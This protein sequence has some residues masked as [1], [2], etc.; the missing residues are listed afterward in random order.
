MSPFFTVVIPTYNCADYL[1]RAL[2]SVFSQTYQNF[3][4]IVVDN[5]STDHTKDVLRSFNDGRLMVIKVN[6]N[7]IIAYSRNKGIENAKG[8]WIA[9]LD[10]DDIWKP[11][12]L[13]KVKKS[14]NQNTEVVLICHDEHYVEN[15]K[16]KKRLRYGPAVKNLYQKLL[17]KGNCVSTSATCI[18]KNIA[19]ET[20]GFS[21][22]KE[23]KTAED[24]EYW[25]RLA[26]V[27]QFYFIKE[28]LGEFHI[29]DKNSSSDIH[30]HTSAGIAVKEYHFSLWLSKF[31]NM[32]KKVNYGR[33]KMYADTGAT[34][35]RSNQFTY[36]REYAIKAI[37]F[38]PWYWKVWI[39]LL[40]GF[41]RIK[42]NQ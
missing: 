23:F 8:D 19:I 11:K 12:K 4:I 39:V 42:I 20:G 34:Y 29:H 33:G 32:N 37:K 40:I 31:P 10:S 35:I 7:G 27:G 21:E 30:I 6:N 36:V 3:E 28:I 15:S 2:N 17:F 18:R 38:N 25:I 5:S 22:R 24:Y 41:L 9:F 13:E 26:Q 14:A 16:I 1:K